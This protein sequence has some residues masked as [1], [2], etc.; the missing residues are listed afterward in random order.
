M[1]DWSKLLYLLGV[2][3][4]VWMG[5]RFVKNN[6]NAF[7]RENLSRSLYTTG[8]LALG[9]IALIAFCVWMLRSSV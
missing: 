8:L 4:F 9:L 1:M 6:P 3:F 2:A 5:Y 7:S